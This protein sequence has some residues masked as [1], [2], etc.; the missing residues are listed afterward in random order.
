MPRRMG[1]QQAQRLFLLQGNGGPRQGIC[2]VRYS[3]QQNSF[4]VCWQER[5]TNTFV[6]IIFTHFH[7]QPRN[8][9]TKP[10]KSAGNCD[11]HAADLPSQGFF[12]KMVLWFSQKSNMS[13][14]ISILKPQK[15]FYLDLVLCMLVIFKILATQL[16]CAKN[17]DIER[18]R[19]VVKLPRAREKERGEDTVCSVVHII[20]S[21]DVISEIHTRETQFPMWHSSPRHCH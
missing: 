5:T 7:P 10:K 14:V 17:H 16:S 19:A 6:M 20:F 8:S 2:V 15:Y 1:G 9:T 12:C 4:F 11:L 18:R 13:K 21:R 3:H